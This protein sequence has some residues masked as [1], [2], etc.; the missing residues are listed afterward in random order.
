[1]TAKLT[2]TRRFLK[3]LLVALLFLCLCLALPA[4][5]RSVWQLDFGILRNNSLLLPALGLQL[6]ASLLFVQAWKG[7][8]ALY[9]DY[10][11]SFA[12]CAAH[13]GVTLLGKYLPGKIWGLLGRSWLLG[14]RDLPAPRALNLLLV[15]QY[16]TFFTGIMLGAAALLA[17]YQPVG[18]VAV[19]LLGTVG[20]PVSLLFYDRVIGVVTRLLGRFTNRLSPDAAPDSQVQDLRVCI[21]AFVVYLMH[22]LATSLVLYLLFNT[23]FADQQFAGFLVL[24]AAIPLAMLAGF[25]A[26]WAPGGIGIREGA[27]VGIIA[28]QFPVELGVT[29]ALVYRIICVMIDLVL[30]GF[31]TVYL[32]RVAPELISAEHTDRLR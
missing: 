12:E 11:Y 27:I 19:L 28:L 10:R 3:P 25:V 6:L 29:V 32:T 9:P 31:A 30:G 26:V 15:D 18:A 13:I 24:T 7:L 14:K 16:I 20:F 21:V 2:A 22:W 17:L 5:L 23:A 4:L 8:T 1:M